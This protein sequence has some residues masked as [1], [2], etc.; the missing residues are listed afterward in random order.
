MW[1][2]E[3]SRFGRVEISLMVFASTEFVPSFA[4]MKGHWSNSPARSR[5]YITIPVRIRLAML[6]GS[7]HKCMFTID[8]ISIFPNTFCSFYLDTRQNIWY[9]QWPPGSNKVGMIKSQV[10]TKVLRNEFY[11]LLVTPTSW[12]STCLVWHFGAECHAFWIEN[13][14]L[15]HPEKHIGSPMGNRTSV[16]PN[17][18]W[19]SLPKATASPSGSAC[20]F[21]RAIAFSYT[22]RLVFC[23]NGQINVAR[24]SDAQCG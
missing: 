23:R 14:F 16:P 8:T 1:W 2:F 6:S 5:D 4:L 21:R 11:R 22:K 10:T 12:I 19:K 24:I 18:K 20:R 3:F 17:R 9:S 7:V 15:F 13:G